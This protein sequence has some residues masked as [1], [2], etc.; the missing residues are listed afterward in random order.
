MLRSRFPNCTHFQ[1]PPAVL[2]RKFSLRDRLSIRNPSLIRAILAPESTNTAQNPPVQ[3][4]PPSSPRSG[5]HSPPVRSPPGTPTP[6]RQSQLDELLLARL[7]ELMLLEQDLI[8][9]KESIMRKEKQLMREKEDVLNK[10][11]ALLKE[12]ESIMKK[13][14]SNM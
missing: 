14:M 13:L 5:T 2:Q 9:K 4:S 12:K 1:N 3:A 10:E 6:D 7:E 11:K 8:A